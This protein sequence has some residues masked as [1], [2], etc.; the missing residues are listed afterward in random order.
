MSF[1]VFFMWCCIFFFRG[2]PNGVKDRK[3]CYSLYLIGRSHPTHQNQAGQPSS[4]YTYIYLRFLLITITTTSYILGKSSSCVAV[5][6]EGQSSV[7]PHF[8][9]SHQTIPVI[10]VSWKSVNMEPRY[11]TKLQFC[12]LH[13]DVAPHFNHLIKRIPLIEVSWKSINMEPRYLTKCAVLKL[14]YHCCPLFW[15]S[16][17]KIPVIEVSWKFIKKGQRYLTKH[18]VLK[19]A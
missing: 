13:R 9:L 16:H 3:L 7:A 15:L 18:I 19:L 2:C 6:Q 12:H 1:E 17:Q 4:C 8:Q 11:L 14:A 5:L 10:E